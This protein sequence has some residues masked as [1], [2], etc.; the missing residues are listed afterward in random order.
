MSIL[1]VEDNPVTVR[2]MDHILK[3]RGYAIIVVNDDEGSGY[4]LLLKE[5]KLLSRSL[6]PA[7]APS[8]PQSPPEEQKRE[9]SG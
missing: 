6:P 3:K 4:P 7:S 1:I 5:L 8:S 2:V 9:E